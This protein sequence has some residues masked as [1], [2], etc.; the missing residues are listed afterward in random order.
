MAPSVTIHVRCSHCSTPASVEFNGFDYD[1]AVE[2]HWA[3]PD[4]GRTNRI[5]AIGIVRSVRRKPDDGSS[6]DRVH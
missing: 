5:G 1:D 2:G 3:C 6:P 4:C